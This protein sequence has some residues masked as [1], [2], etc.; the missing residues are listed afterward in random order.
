MEISTQAHSKTIKNRAMGNIS[1]IQEKSIL[2]LSKKVIK[3]E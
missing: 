2:D 1:I 3:M